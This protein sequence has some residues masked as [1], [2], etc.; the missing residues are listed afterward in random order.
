MA[1]IAATH[2]LATRAGAAASSGRRAP[3]A[4]RRC[5]LTTRAAATPW[6][7]AASGFCRTNN[8]FGPSDGARRGVFVVPEA[9]KGYGFGYGYGYGF[10][11]GHGYGE[12]ELGGKSGTTVAPSSTAP[13]PASSSSGAAGFKE[14][15]AKAGKIDKSTIAALGGAALLSYGLISNVFYVSSLLGAMYTSC[16]VHALSPLVS[17]FFIFYPVWAI[18]LTSC[19]ICSQVD[20]AAMQTFVTTYFGLWMIQNFLRPARMGLS[21]AISPFTDKIVEFF[22]RYVPG[23]KKP[24]AFALTVFCVNVLG[25][26]AYM[27]GGFFL[28]TW[29]TGVPLELGSLKSLLAAGKAEVAAKAIA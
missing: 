26:F 4:S 25:T 19:F 3:R 2:P 21:V 13:A 23:N 27:F 28:I 7:E 11:Y 15:W 5:A 29:L 22:R 18:S 12:P 6:L 10:K 16:K 24:L 20:K 14:W 9:S 17:L 1:S 8:V